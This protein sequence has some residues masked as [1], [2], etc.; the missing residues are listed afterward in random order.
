M[1]NFLL[2]FIHLIYPNLC[3]ACGENLVKGEEAICLKCIFNLPKT[4]YHLQADNPIEKRFWGRTQIENATAFFHFQKGTE[5]QRLLHEL[6]Y[7]GNQKVGVVL[8]KYLGN[9][10]MLTEKFRS[11]DLIVPVPL[12][13]NKQLKR[14]YNQSSCIAAGIGKIMQKPID[15]KH[16]IRVIENPTQTKKSVYERWENTDGIFENTN[17]SVFKHKH[18]LLIDDVLTT[19]STLLACADELLKSDQCKVS[20]ATLAVA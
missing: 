3:S 14:G 17:T 6:K 18:V 5:F 15:E 1:S 2:D 19:G 9:E 10:L 20:V 4:N 11:I 13:K 16:L 8:G 12:H 7:K